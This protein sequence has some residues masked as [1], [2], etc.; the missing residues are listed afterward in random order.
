MAAV[1]VVDDDPDVLATVA[2]II[3]QSGH[4]VAT[5]ASGLAALAVLDEDKPIDLLLTDVIMPGLNGF[6]LARMAHLRRPSLKVLYLTGFHEAATAMR[7]VGDRLG[8]L[9]TKPIQPADLRREVA[10]ALTKAA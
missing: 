7:D 4:K 5:A 2:K 10:D 9:L 1:L 8:K 6:N 3:E